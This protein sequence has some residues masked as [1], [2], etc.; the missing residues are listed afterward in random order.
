MTLA[1]P[2]PGGPSGENA[3]GW[4]SH[5]ADLPPPRTV[6]CRQFNRRSSVR[7]DKITRE[8]AIASPVMPPPHPCP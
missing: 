1:A 7:L 8:G 3:F 6:R 5:R 4:S 2:R